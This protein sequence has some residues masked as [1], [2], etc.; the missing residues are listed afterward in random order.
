M[1]ETSTTASDPSSR[2]Q[3]AF[4]IQRQVSTLGSTS[5]GPVSLKTSTSP[6]P[7]QLKTKTT[8]VRRMR[9]IIS[10]DPEWSL[11]IVPL[12]TELCIQHIVK[13]FQSEST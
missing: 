8:N 1:Q 9:R 12:L 13:N 5:P 11:A 2:S 7:S 3:S 4:N 6:A 10:E